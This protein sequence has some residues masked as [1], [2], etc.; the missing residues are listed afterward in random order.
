MEHV[1]VLTLNNSNIRRNVTEERWMCSP[2]GIDVEDL[3]D[4]V[5]SIAGLQEQL[6]DI[7]KYETL[8]SNFQKRF[9][10]VFWVKVK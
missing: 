6:S 2:F 1:E 3:A 8:R 9:Q 5:S 7:Q 10:S 4:D